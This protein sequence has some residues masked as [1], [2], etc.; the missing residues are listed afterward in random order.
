MTI[1]Y[2]V[3]TVAMPD[4]SPSRAWDDV[5]ESIPE[6][7]ADAHLAWGFSSGDAKLKWLNHDPA[8]PPTALVNAA[9]ATAVE[10]RDIGGVRNLLIAHDLEIALKEAHDD[11]D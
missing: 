3:L 6:M 10:L 8:Q 2:A 11:T 5:Q 4:A 7:I 1:R 9:R